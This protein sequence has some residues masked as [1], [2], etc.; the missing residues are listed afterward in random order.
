MKPPRYLKVGD[1]CRVE[2]E[3]IGYIEN[4][5]FPSLEEL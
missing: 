1:V 3:G 5:S 4:V 2:I